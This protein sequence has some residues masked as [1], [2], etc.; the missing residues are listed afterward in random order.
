MPT[1]QDYLRTAI[2]ERL[3][4]DR[5]IEI[6]HCRRL[7]GLPAL[8]VRSTALEP[9]QRDQP[10][11]IEDEIH[12]IHEVQGKRAATKELPQ[13]C[14]VLLRESKPPKSHPP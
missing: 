8:A 13:V 14:L 3:Q 1:P 10:A 4:T 2:R 9:A 12:D 11:Q 7:G 6:V 5:A